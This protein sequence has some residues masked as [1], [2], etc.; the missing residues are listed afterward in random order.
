MAEKKPIKKVTTKKHLAREQREAKQT[1]LILTISIA[2]GV[3]ILGLLI[4]GIVDQTIVRPRTPIAQVGETTIKSREFKSFVQYTRVQ[5]LNQAFQYYTFSQQFGDFGGSFLQNAQTLVMQ[6]SQPL[7]FGSEV[8]DEM[9]DNIIIL[10]ESAK[11]GITVSQ[12][13]I[14]SA[15]QAAFGFFPDGTPTPTLTATIQSTPTLSETQ[16]SL[17]TL[18][19]TATA[20]EQPGDE[21][22]ASASVENDSAELDD[23]GSTVDDSLTDM[24]DAVEVE[25]DPTSTPQAT[26]TITLT[27]TPYTTQIFA[28]NINDFNS[29]YAPYNFDI[30]DLRRIFEV[31]LLRDKLIEEIAQDLEP[32]KSEV[33]A[34]HI[35]VETLEEANQLFLRLEEGEDF[36]EL[37]ATH[38]MDESNRFEGGNLGWFDQNTMVTPFSEVAFSLEVG[39]ISDPV[40]TT[41]GFHIIQVLGKRDIQVPPSEFRTQQ[42]NYFLN[43]LTDTRNS[44]DDIIIFEGWED[45]V[46]TNPEVPQQLIFELF[47]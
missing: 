20:T 15:I 10:E 30:E 23:D 47:Q 46:P 9:I 17:I 16:L 27:P 32:V 42:I 45:H 37:A 7:S 18:T 13:E 4:Y 19:P 35:L 6:L 3:I 1:R 14:D 2:V 11:R 43:W 38:S 29:I 34:R 36:H 41:F 33:W 8:L 28:Q 44:R 25:P 39:E 24:T 31:Q 12:A 40:E 21:D 22:E 5:V 26:P